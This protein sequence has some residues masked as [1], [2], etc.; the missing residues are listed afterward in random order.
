MEDPRENALWVVLNFSSW[1]ILFR[2]NIN[3][4][5]FK[6][7]IKYSLSLPPACPYFNKYAQELI[8]F[9]RP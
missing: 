7:E 3:K 4:M 1:K 2:A 9:A 8:L 5:F 6:N